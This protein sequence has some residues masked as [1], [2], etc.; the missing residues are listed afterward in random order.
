M[1][2]DRA[3]A[4]HRRA[5]ERVSE[6]A[7]ALPPRAPAAV[8]PPRRG[9]APAA[10]R[11][12]LPG[13]GA[14]AIAVLGLAFGLSATALVLSR[15][16]DPGAVA[17]GPWVARPQVGTPS[18]DPYAAA[19]LARSGAVPM[20]ANEGL[21][22]RA[23]TDDTGYRLLRSCSYRVAG[24]MPA[25]RFWTLTATGTDGRTLDNPAQRTGFTSRDVVRALG[26]RFVIE[27]APA[28]RPGNWLP[29]SGE[30]PLTLTLRLYDTPLAGNGAEVA[31]ASMPSLTRVSCAPAGATTDAAR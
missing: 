6:P 2:P 1:R 21:A 9:A 13:A 15:G 7:T 11:G 22:F 8:E 12:G 3:S 30:G 17:I 16:W 24:A 14:L 31:T 4:L 19:D 5:L 28:A 25:A 29:L 20:A 26:G 27:V 10:A 23:T 18:I